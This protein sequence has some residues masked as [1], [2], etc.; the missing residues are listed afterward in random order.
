M[1]WLREHKAFQGCLLLALEVMDGGH[2]LSWT[3]DSEKV[4]ENDIRRLILQPPP[5]SLPGHKPSFGQCLFYTGPTLGEGG[6]K[7]LIPLYLAFEGCTSTGPSE[8]LKCLHTPH[9]PLKTTEWATHSLTHCLAMIKALLTTG[10]N[11]GKNKSS[12]LKSLKNMPEDSLAYLFIFSLLQRGTISI[13]FSGEFCVMKK[14]MMS[15]RTR[16]SPAP[17][18]PPTLAC[19]KH[20]SYQ[21][22]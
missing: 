2:R 19:A 18:P 16:A 4:R 17:A 3:Q 9:L 5:S 1:V 14:Q 13:T 8:I 12:F 10:P 20:G 22:F 21:P 15:F 7:V 6:S 11:T